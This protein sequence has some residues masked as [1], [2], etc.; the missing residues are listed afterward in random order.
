MQDND[1]MKKRNGA[2]IKC[3]FIIYSLICLLPGCETIATVWA[4]EPV[5]I[6]YDRKELEQK[7][8]AR[9]QSF[10]NK[11]VIPSTFYP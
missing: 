1:N 10:L 7:W 5:A 4:G 11:G 2:Y 6:E 9:I 8:Q 3:I